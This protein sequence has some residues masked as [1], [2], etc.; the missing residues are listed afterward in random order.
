[1]YWKGKLV[2]ESSREF[3]KKYNQCKFKADWLALEINGSLRMHIVEIDIDWKSLLSNIMEEESRYSDHVFTFYELIVLLLSDGNANCVWLYLFTL[4]FS[5]GEDVDCV[6]INCGI[7]GYISTFNF[8]SDGI[9]GCIFTHDFLSGRVS[10]CIFTRDFL[11]GEVAGCI[12]AFNSLSGKVA[13]YSSLLF[14]FLS[15]VVAGYIS[16]FNFLSGGVAGCISTCDSLSNGIAGCIF[17]HDFYLV[18]LL[19]V[20]S[21]VIFVW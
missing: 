14:D 9:A 10:Y 15:D 5:S 13:N 11:S 20:F 19:V 12:F 3:M 7:S 4:D 2:R 17:I 6:S 21:H 18:E 8:L 1:M 16:T